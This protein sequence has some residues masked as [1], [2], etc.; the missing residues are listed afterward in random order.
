METL[1]TSKTEGPAS[2]SG[3]TSVAVSGTCSLGSTSF[4]GCSMTF[5]ARV[6]GEPCGHDAGDDHQYEG[7]GNQR[8]GRAPGS[9]LSANVGRCGVRK[10]W[11]DS[12]VL[13]PLKMSV[14]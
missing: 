9:C 12:A 5:L 6:A 10:I 3:L 14:L 8:E 2:A 4:S 11:V 7:Y 13:A 1:S